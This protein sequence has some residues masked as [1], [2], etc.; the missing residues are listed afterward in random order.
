MLTLRGFASKDAQPL[1]F[2]QVCG[3]LLSCYRFT[4]ACL[5]PRAIAP[6]R[7]PDS[8][9]TKHNEAVIDA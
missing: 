7:R 6:E 2:L 1:Q 5:T 4:Q 3:C 9:R 8:F